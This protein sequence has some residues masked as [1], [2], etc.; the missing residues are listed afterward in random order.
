MVSLKNSRHPI[1]NVAIFGL[2][3]NAVALHWTSIYVGSTPWIIL[4]IGQTLFFLPLA[5]VKK[6]GM[7]FYPL[8][9]LVMEEIRV[10]YP[11]G[12][13][14]WLRIAFSQADSPFRRLAIFGG[15]SGLT[16]MVLCISWVLFTLI[17]AR[18]LVVSLPLLPILLLLIPT[19]ITSSGEINTVMI[20]GDVPQLGLD[21]N[22]RATAVFYKHI[23]ESR[24]ALEENGNVD[25]LLWPENAVDV[26]PFTNPKV[27]AAL[28]SL[29]KPIILGAVIRQDNHFQNVSI[30]WTEKVQDV[31]VKQ[32]LTPFGEYIPLRSIASKISP[33]TDDVVDF[34][35]GNTPKIFAI[36]QAR[37]APIICFELIDDDLV[38][39]AAKGSNLI[40]VQTNSATFGRSPE[41]AQQ[42][43]ITRIRAIEHGRNILSV[44]TTG[45][46]ASIDYTGNILEQTKIHTS[47][48]I[49]AKPALITSQTPRD[50][51]GDWALIGALIWLLMPVVIDRRLRVIRR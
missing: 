9:F 2:V 11:F 50:K 4:V 35:P 39:N 1:A 17:S 22:S 28:N 8:I 12:G 18:T 44:S 16:A 6:Y 27:S 38:N 33:Y 3:F 29:L 5:L 24:K 40:V 43:A 14:G 45:I 36:K 42:L 19:S 46:S 31:Y 21:F 13:F 32:H 41:S 26:D 37:I 25:F 10:R 47:A 30:N 15:A 20:Q 23:T 49:F 7:A 48:H 51:A 34:L